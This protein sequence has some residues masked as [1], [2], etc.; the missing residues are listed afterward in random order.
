MTNFI[1]QQDEE[2]PEELGEGGK[3]K[4]KKIKRDLGALKKQK[5]DPNSPNASRMPF[6]DLRDID[7]AERAKILRE[8]A[9]R[10]VLGPNN[11]PSICYYTVMNAAVSLS[12]VEVKE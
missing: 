5:N 8:C 10:Q 4:K 7:K 2:E 3:P 12:S 6:P 11:L 9:K 1:V